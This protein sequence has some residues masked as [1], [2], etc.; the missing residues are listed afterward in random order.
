MTDKPDADDRPDLPEVPEMPDDDGPTK[1]P[2]KLLMSRE[3]R[4]WIAGLA[5]LVVAFAA[6]GA[7]GSEEA[8]AS[9]VK[10]SPDLDRTPSPKV[11]VGG[12]ESLCVDLKANSD[13]TNIPS[14]LLESLC[15]IGK[16]PSQLLAPAL[17]TAASDGAP[18]QYSTPFTVGFD[19]A[20][21]EGALLPVVIDETA[22]TATVSGIG[23]F[24]EVCARVDAKV[25]VEAT[26][27]ALDANSEFVVLFPDYYVA[28]PTATGSGALQT[29]MAIEVSGA[30]PSGADLGTWPTV[31]CMVHVFTP[32]TQGA[33]PG[34]LE[35]VAPLTSYPPADILLQLGDCTGSEGAAECLGII[36]DLAHDT[37]L[38]VAGPWEAIRITPTMKYTWT[39]GSR[40]D[41]DKAR[42]T[43]SPGGTMRADV[44][45]GSFTTKANQHGKDQTI[46]YCSA[47]QVQ[48][49]DQAWDFNGNQHL[50]DDAF[51]LNITYVKV[52]GDI[53][54]VDVPCATGILAAPSDNWNGQGVLQCLAEA[55]LRSAAIL[56]GG[57]RLLSIVEEADGD[58][59]IVPA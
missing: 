53:G 22:I 4:G 45:S 11:P 30:G 17:K 6:I 33:I 58:F 12:T 5:A 43:L 34:L 52:T 29:R 21:A 37:A 41:E 14:R 16:N 20:V 55:D 35:S 15:A 13:L 32:Y 42:L 28:P 36:S 57:A 1:G 47:M 10:V 38:T 44:G 18:V 46:P 49:V 24:T 48:D 59:V 50:D 25:T 40:M 7:P 8:P 23:A 27:S 56:P 54:K 39:D 51:C 31:K 19:L 26:G 3:V 2:R 9:V